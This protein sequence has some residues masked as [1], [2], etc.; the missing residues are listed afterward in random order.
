MPVEFPKA[1]AQM[2]PRRK[3]EGTSATAAWIISIHSHVQVTRKCA[4][5]KTKTPLTSDLPGTQNHAGWQV[6]QLKPSCGRSLQQHP[7]ANTSQH[8]LESGIWTTQCPF[9]CGCSYSASS[10]RLRFPGGRAR[11]TACC[12]VLM[13]DVQLPLP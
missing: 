9:D 5:T 11:V 3:S 4:S 10:T 7:H 12:S 13:L 6:C 8:D 2:V 1:T